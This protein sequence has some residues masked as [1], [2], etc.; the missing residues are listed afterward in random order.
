MR[1]HL[2]D[3]KTEAL[4]EEAA[5]CPL[6]PLPLLCKEPSRHPHTPTTTINVSARNSLDLHFP[7]S[8]LGRVGEP[9]ALSGP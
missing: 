5:S 8:L 9:Q 3:R 1:T 4:R 2:L 7:R 6:G